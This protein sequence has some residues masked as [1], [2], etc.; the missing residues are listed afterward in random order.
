MGNIVRYVS[1][2]L[3]F[4][5]F[6]IFERNFEIKYLSNIL[7]WSNSHESSIISSG[8]TKY[9]KRNA[10]YIAVVCTRPQCSYNNSPHR[11]VEKTPVDS[12]FTTSD[13]YRVSNFHFFDSK[14]NKEFK[15]FAIKKNYC[16]AHEA[17][18]PPPPPRPRTHN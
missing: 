17:S 4:G 15:N 3:T 13:N 8:K 10:D 12:S 6:G 16:N 1:K 18:F 14:T 5:L 2:I 7:D 11:V 9:E